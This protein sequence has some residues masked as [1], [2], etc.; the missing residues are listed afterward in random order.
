MVKYVFAKRFVFRFEHHCIDCIE[1]ESAIVYE[2]AE[3]I[4]FLWIENQFSQN[5]RK[6]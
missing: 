4:L 2:N 6:I 5:I 3:N 1:I